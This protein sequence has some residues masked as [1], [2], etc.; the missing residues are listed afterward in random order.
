MRRYITVSTTVLAAALLTASGASAQVGFGFG[1]GGGPSFPVSELGEDAGTGFHLQASLAVSG[2][3]VETRVDGIFQRFTEKG[4]GGWIRG[5]GG[6]A[7]ALLP[8]PLPGAAPYVIAGL[9]LIHT[10]DEHGHEEPGTQFA[11]GIGGGVRLGLVG[12]GVFLEARYLD[13]GDHQR[14]VPLT[15]GIMF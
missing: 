4:D 11:F 1:V 3:P 13:A 2:L 10:E 7:N 9:G 14:S 5:I 6:I 8:L 12:R 15:V